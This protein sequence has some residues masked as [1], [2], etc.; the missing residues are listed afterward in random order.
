ML[1]RAVCGRANVCGRRQPNLVPVPAGCAWVPAKTPGPCRR[2]LKRKPRMSTATFRFYAELNDF[3]PERRRQRE[4]SHSFHGQPAVKDVIEALGVPH[5]EVEVVLINGEIADFSTRLRDGARV[6]VY[7]MFES[8]DVSPVVR[9]RPRPLRKPRFVADNHLG[10]LAGL[11]RLVGFDTLYKNDFDDIELTRVA[12]EQ[13]RILLTRD[14]GL[15]KRSVIT[16]GYCV[17]NSEP[18]RQLLEVLRRF[19]L[20]DVLE[21]FKRCLACNG[22]LRRVAREAVAQRLP[23]GVLAEQEEFRECPDCGRIY[24]QGSHYRHLRDLVDDVIRA[25]MSPD[26]TRPGL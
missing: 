4:F 9:L 6:S 23:P 11:L 7:P 3:L 19:D 15:L 21:P 18:R 16:H 14:R 1:R 26:E 17:R 8:L 22:L 20:P 5:T 25:S 13:K 24:W 10:K 12:V 2:D